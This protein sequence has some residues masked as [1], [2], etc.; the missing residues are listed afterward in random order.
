MITKTRPVLLVILA[1]VAGGAHPQV[2]LADV[3]DAM[4]LADY[5]GLLEQIA[6]AAR[7]GAQAYLAAYRQRCGQLLSTD[8]LRGAMS[9]DGGEP[10]LMAMIR[11]S[12]L[13]DAKS[14]AALARNVSCKGRK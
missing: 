4:P 10:T 3:P 5:L 2:L 6:P 9:V 12:Q 13:Q 11:A 7:Q 14:L 8:E 1:F